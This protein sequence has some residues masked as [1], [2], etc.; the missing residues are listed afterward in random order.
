MPKFPSLNNSALC[1]WL[2]ARPT[3]SRLLLCR[4]RLE[5]AG[6]YRA[7]GINREQRISGP[8]IDTINL[9]RPA[10]LAC[11]DRE[12]APPIVAVTIRPRDTLAQKPRRDERPQPRIAQKDKDRSLM[13]LIRTL[14][15]SETPAWRDANPTSISARIAANFFAESS[16][17][18]TARVQPAR[19]TSMRSAAGNFVLSAAAAIMLKGSSRSSTCRR[20]P[21]EIGIRRT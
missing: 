3:R 19:A 13:L 15:P 1:R 18:N 12:S 9:G 14:A 7:I 20:I 16:C 5:I 11:R 17:N 4:L 21:I 8:R 2:A 10:R 6:S